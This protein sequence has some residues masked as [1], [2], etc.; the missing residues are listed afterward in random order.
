MTVPRGGHSHAGISRPDVLTA[1]GSLD[2][3]RMSHSA[4]YLPPG[5]PPSPLRMR[6]LA[7]GYRQID[8]ATLA[9]RSR[10]QIRRLEAGECEPGWRTVQALAVALCCTSDELFPP[11]TNVAGQGDAGER[12]GRRDH[13]AAPA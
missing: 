12:H 1:G 3:Y 2:A 5:N 11:T 13:D 9:G 10:E 7:L 8:V 6:R 4:A